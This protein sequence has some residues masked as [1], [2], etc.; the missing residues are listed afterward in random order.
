[1]ADFDYTQSELEM[2]R[3]MKMQQEHLKDVT[4]QVDQ[5]TEELDELEAKLKRILQKRN[6]SIDEEQLRK[7]IAT[8]EIDTPEEYSLV[9]V[10]DTVDWDALVEKSAR[11]YSGNPVTIEHLLSD[12]EIKYGL[13]EIEAINRSF[14]K[15]TGLSAKDM[16]FLATAI[17]LQSA[18]WFILQKM[19]T[20]AAKGASAVTKAATGTAVQAGKS[21]AIKGG[22]KTAINTITNIGKTVASQSFGQLISKA[23]DAI[24]RNSDSSSKDTTSAGTPGAAK[25]NPNRSWRDIIINCAPYDLQCVGDIN[26]IYGVG[27]DDFTRKILGKEPVWGCIIGSMNYLTDTVTFDNYNTYRVVRDPE[28]RIVE[29]ISMKQ[30]FMDAVRSV[31]EDMMRLPVAVYAQIMK[32]QGRTLSEAEFVSTFSEQRI[33]ALYTHQYEMFTKSKRYLLVGDQAMIASLINMTIGLYHTLQYDPKKDGSFQEYEART[34]TILSMSNAMSAA[35]NTVFTIATQNWLAL[36]AGGM[37]I[38]FNRFM[39]DS[40][41]TTHLKE[42]MIKQKLDDTFKIE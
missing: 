26:H 12:K 3:V 34:R 30:M 18:R 14:S 24:L 40:M 42:N 21:A 11:E 6:I 17:T 2:N 36:D 25:H 32:Q 39:D 19:F 9:K 22:T 38:A 31:N 8:D 10:E 27:I 20:V 28:L 4:S 13:N 5:N 1:M 35:T 29:K 15:N 23:N 33:S 41:F 37:I 16:G 7:A